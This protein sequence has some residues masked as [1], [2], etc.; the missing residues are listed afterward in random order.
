MVDEFVLLF[1]VWI[2][3]FYSHH[4]VF[5]TMIF[6]AYYIKLAADQHVLY[7]FFSKSFFKT[8]KE[9]EMYEFGSFRLLLTQNLK[10]GS[11]VFSSF[12]HKVTNT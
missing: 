8:P 12:M 5:Y 7:T 10:K 11:S 1:R 2:C 9:A 6:P 4:L 3:E